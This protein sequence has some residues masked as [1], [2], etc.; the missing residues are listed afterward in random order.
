MRPIYKG[1]VIGVLGTIVS[2]GLLGPCLALGISCGFGIVLFL[3][4]FNIYLG[5]NNTWFLT[6]LFTLFFDLG[7]VAWVLHSEIIRDPS[8]GGTET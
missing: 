6:I 3:S 4:F 1:L 7:M 8:S 5:L 2:I